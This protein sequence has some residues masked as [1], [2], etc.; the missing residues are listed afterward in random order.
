M[1]LILNSGIKLNKKIAFLSIMLLI[2]LVVSIQNDYKIIETIGKITNF[3]KKIDVF[4]DVAKS[5]AKNAQNNANLKNEDKEN[6]EIEQEA[7]LIKNTLNEGRNSVT[8]KNKNGHIRYDLEGKAH[9]Q[10]KTPHKHIYKN[11]LYEG[12][13]KSVSELSESP[14][15]LTKE[16]LEIIR[17]YLQK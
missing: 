15:K 5:V 2:G 8:I 17:T 3:A 4:N 9:E 16:D 14:L 11:N 7:K 6:Q 13:I 12:E 10:I 1:E